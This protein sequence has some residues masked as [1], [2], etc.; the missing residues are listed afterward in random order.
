VSGDFLGAGVG[1]P[2]SLDEQGRF[3]LAHREDSI[4]QSIWTILSTSLGER[5]MRPSFGC[6]LHDHVFGVNSEA[7]IGGL[8][9]AVQD[10]LAEWEPRIEVLSVR[11]VPD[12]TRTEHLLIEVSYQVRASNSRFNL[13]YP[14]YLGGG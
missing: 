7:T 12:P 13:V 4:R 6:S 8:T 14:F 3:R 5:A 2:A 1:Y 10:A 9:V 11:A